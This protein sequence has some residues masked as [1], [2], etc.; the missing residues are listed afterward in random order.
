MASD[1]ELQDLVAGLEAIEGD[2]RAAIP[3]CRFLLGGEEE[4]NRTV[5]GPVVRWRRVRGVPSSTV[6]Q[7]EEG[8]QG[9]LALASDL[10]EVTLRITGD[11]RV[12]PGA[13]QPRRVLLRASLRVLLALRESINARWNGM[14]EEEPWEMV[15]VE[16]ADAGVPIDW[17]VRLRFDVLATAPLIAAVET[18]EPTYEVNHG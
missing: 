13:Q 6:Y 5:S 18:V 1:D 4:D 3:G 2:V 9:Q 17:L 10:V 12:P 8:N 14:Y 7:R 16:Q 11:T 15:A